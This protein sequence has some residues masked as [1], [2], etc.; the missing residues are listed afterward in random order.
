MAIQPEAMAAYKATAT[1]RWREKEKSLSRRRVRALEMAQQAADFLRA[2]YGVTE[3]ILFGS[4]AHGHW[5]SAT[6]DIDLAVRDIPKH[7][8]FAAV[9]RLQDLSSEFG[10]DL[11]DLHNCKPALRKAVEAEGILL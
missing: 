9:A 10:V 5:F 7:D 3:V 11:V 4:L 6:S 2:E 8:Y 1:R